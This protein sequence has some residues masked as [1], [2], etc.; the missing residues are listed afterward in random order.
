MHVS[1]LDRSADV[2]LAGALEERLDVT[3]SPPAAPALKTELGEALL[4]LA[5]RLDAVRLDEV[6]DR[7]PGRITVLGHDLP[8]HLK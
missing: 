3:R 8:L 5:P 4:L 7:E 1:E 6:P 2:A